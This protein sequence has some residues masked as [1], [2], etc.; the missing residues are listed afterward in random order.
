M[1]KIL[2]LAPHTD[3]GELGCGGTIS[4]LVEQGNEVFY[5]AFSTC[6]ESVPQGFPKDV[7]SK[8]LKEAVKQLGVKRENLFILDFKVRLFKENRQS[9]LDEM[10]KLNRQINPDIV[11]APS[12]HDIHQ[13][14]S[15]VAEEAMRAF[16]RTTIFCYEVPWNHYTFNNQS[17]S[18]LEKKH[19]D[20]KIQALSCY[21]SQ[22]SRNYFSR[23]FIESNAT[24]HGVQIGSTYAEVFEVVRFIM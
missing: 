4:K 22:A 7:L 13:D 14:H 9:L 15:A 12:I 16:K 10:I 2:V 24:V 20:N 11:F 6:E 8:E 19:I 21:N 1:K 5:V 3:D 18:I 17:F 23:E